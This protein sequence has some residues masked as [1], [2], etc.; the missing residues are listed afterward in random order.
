MHAPPSTAPLPSAPKRMLA[1]LGLLLVGLVLA[2]V[3]AELFARWV[4]RDGVGLGQIDIP[5]G[6]F[7]IVD[8]LKTPVPGFRGWIVMPGTQVELR[9]DERGLRAGALD[10]AQPGWLALGDSFTLAGQVPAEHSFAARLQQ[11]LGRPVYNAGVDGYSTY[12]ATERYRRLVD[13]L[14]VEGVILTICLG[15]DL[16]DNQVWE[17]RTR[18]GGHPMDGAQ[19]ARSSGPLARA[20]AQHSYLRALIGT[21]RR[22]ARRDGREARDGRPVLPQNI[23][24]SREGTEHLRQLLRPTREAV[25]QLQDELRQRGH[26]LVV[27]FAPEAIQVHPDLLVDTFAHD[28]LDPAQADA[29]APNRA[30]SAMLGELGIQACDPTEALRRAVAAGERPHLRWDGHWSATGH[31][32]YTRTLLDCMAREGQ[33]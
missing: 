28:G 9:F 15:N 1:R 26:R 16:Y 6:I 30:L 18:A 14:P 13:S 8:G 4:T 11:A 3:L 19:E 32:I 29:D 5:P 21:R 22:A 17:E 33:P 12:E 20:F 25:R 31:A 7:E 2:L 24:F 23:I 10:S 27:G